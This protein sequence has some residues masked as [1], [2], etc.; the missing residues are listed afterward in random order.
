MTAAS[1]ATSLIPRLTLFSG[2]N[3]SLCDTAKA[4]LAKV[5][6]K[7]QF[8]LETIDIHEKGQERWKKKYVYWIPALHLD[9]TEIAKG[10]W[11]AQTL[12]NFYQAERGQGDFQRVHVIEEWRRQ[13]IE[14]LDTFQ[15]GEVRGELLQ[16][17]IYPGDGDWLK[18]MAIW[19]YP[20]GWVAET[21]PTETVRRIIENEHVEHALDDASDDIFFV[22]GD[23][24]VEEITLNTGINTAPHYSEDDDSDDASVTSSILSSS[25]I[26]TPA[27]TEPLPP[28]PSR[29]A[30][31]PL[32]EFASHVL[33]VYNGFMLPSISHRAGLTYT[34]DRH[35]LWQRITSSID[36][37]STLPRLPPWR[38]PD[39]EAYLSPM[40]A[41]MPPPP[42]TTEPPPLPPSAEPLLPAAEPPHSVH[43]YPR[44]THIVDRRDLSP[45][46]SHE[47][48][49]MDIS[50]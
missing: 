11:N 18:N 16:D 3:C 40:D 5:R 47:D 13:R 35:I 49:D 6:Q 32:T 34:T 44:K 20:K 23:G 12:F 21:N 22:F 29:W 41:I 9:N 24:Q 4:E 27:A 36:G 48:E 28:G 8:Q 2:A 10:R 30:Q 19:G 45:I 14:W 25:R 7:R 46:S 42:P 38:Q 37:S 33:P 17:A 31:Y 43:S 1:R 50:E 26:T 15:P 39:C